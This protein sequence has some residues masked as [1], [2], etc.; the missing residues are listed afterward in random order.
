MLYYLQATSDWQTSEGKQNV[1]EI[2]RVIDQAPLISIL[3]RE[4]LAGT[5]SKSVR[6]GAEKILSKAFCDLD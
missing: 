5:L 3:P 2:L 6:M 1:W 4:A